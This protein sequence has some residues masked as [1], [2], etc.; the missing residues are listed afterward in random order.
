MTKRIA[1][2]LAQPGVADCARSLT[3][4][5]RAL[6][7]VLAAALVWPASRRSSETIG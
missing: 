1:A 5:R 2:L 7:R 6:A 3:H 4:G